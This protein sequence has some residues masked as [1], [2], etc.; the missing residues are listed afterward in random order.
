MHH[1]PELLL[2]PEQSPCMGRDADVS[3]M[4]R[5]ASDIMGLLV[6]QKV[7]Q[8]LKGLKLSLVPVLP[9]PCFHLYL[10]HVTL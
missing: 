6:L 10:A 2:C 1:T 5:D 7:L 4:Q 3:I 9:P 8:T